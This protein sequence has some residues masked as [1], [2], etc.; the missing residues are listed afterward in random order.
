MSTTQDVE[1]EI[2]RRLVEYIHPLKCLRNTF[3]PAGR[4]P[5]ETWYSIFR[6]STFDDNAGAKHRISIKALIPISAVCHSWRE[7]ARGHGDLWTDINC[8]DHPDLVRMALDLSQPYPISARVFD[9]FAPYGYPFLREQ[10][11]ETVLATSK[12]LLDNAIRMKHLQLR[13]SDERWYVGGV[14]D[15]LISKP[16]DLRN[17]EFLNISYF[18]EDEALDLE[19]CNRLFELAPKEV[20]SLKLNG[21]HVRCSRFLSWKLAVFHL[22][23]RGLPSMSP[24]EWRMLLNHFA[25]YLEDFLLE[26]VDYPMKLGSSDGQIVMSKLTRVQLKLMTAECI[27]TFM[28]NMQLVMAAKAHIQLESE[29]L[30]PDWVA[31]AAMLDHLYSH[32][33][34]LIFNLE[35]R[36]D[37]FAFRSVQGEAYITIKPAYHSTYRRFDDFLTSLAAVIRAKVVSISLYEEVEAEAPYPWKL[38]STLLPN[39]HDVAISS[40]PP[41]D[42]WEYASREYIE[43]HD[44]RAPR[45]MKTTIHP[46]LRSDFRA[47]SIIRVLEHR[48]ENPSDRGIKAFLATLRHRLSSRRHSTVQEVILDGKCT[49]SASIR[50]AIAQASPP[51]VVKLEDIIVPVVPG[52]MTL[53]GSELIKYRLRVAGHDDAEVLAIQEQKEE[54]AK[55]I[56][57]ARF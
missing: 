40:G 19:Q 2:Q 28:T 21:V 24:E 35:H 4:L 38:C 15:I 45:K 11:W 50:Q 3:T 8:L 18:T 52:T 9:A 31:V 32:E 22:S 26:V 51:T 23:G 55:Y 36:D 5:D 25:P 47:V 54:F 56:Q 27:L 1:I 37:R 29:R 30:G 13:F 33:P 43:T 16:F 57:A 44:V 34:Q 39:V 53:S 48:L 12:L 6:Y 49:I 17:I 10:T 42:I 20:V 7:I 14:K 46:S 41:P